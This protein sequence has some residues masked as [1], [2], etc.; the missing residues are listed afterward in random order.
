MA[1]TYNLKKIHDAPDWQ[2]CADTINGGVKVTCLLQDLRQGT[3]RSN[4]IYR[5]IP[6]VIDVYNPIT[7]G[8][9]TLSGFGVGGFSTAGAGGVFVASAGPNGTCFN[10]GA[11]TTNIPLTT[12]FPAA[13]GINQLANRG[14]GVQGFK[15]R[16]VDPISGKTEESYIVGNTAGTTPTLTISPA[17]SFTPGLSTKYY[18]L[19]GRIFIMGTTGTLFQ[20]YDIATGFLSAALTTTN[21]TAPG[22][23]NGMCVLDELYTPN[24]KLP[25]QGF[26]GN[27]VAATITNTTNA[28]VTGPT[29]GA[30]N[31]QPA[32]A[33]A[34]FQIRIV[35]D[36]TNPNSV[37]QRIKITSH[38]SANPTV[39]T[40]SGVFATAP[41]NTATYVIEGIGDIICMTGGATALSHT[42]AAGGWRADAT[43]ST[44]STLG[45]GSLQIPDRSSATILGI[46]N[47]IWAFGFNSL[48]VNKNNRYS[49]VY[50]STT[51]PVNTIDCLDIATL[52]WSTGIGATGLPFGT[53]GSHSLYTV[54]DP[55][56]NNGTYI[57]CCF[58]FS[59]VY[60]RYDLKN[61]IVEPWGGYSA[62]KKPFS[63]LDSGNIMGICPVIDG[64]VVSSYV[65]INEPSQVTA[66]KGFYRNLVVN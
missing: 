29:G 51:S 58:G 8:W 15:I 25:G 43:W 53:C 13:V 57:Y 37:G 2:P 22:A 6:S 40:C 59:P 12:A 10:I 50:F 38:T 66:S 31:T 26:F 64:A 28:V 54:Y 47:P 65:Y 46:S 56:N 23:D 48:D 17:L 21:L 41:S 14:D 9:L 49:G 19:S 32:N 20:Y 33:W 44:G 36:A 5:L 24:G 34:N 18:L 60:F 63:T 27:L 30:D 35:T 16:F 3:D 62:R 52:S 4:L 45:G 39:Y 61:R 11:T 55:W 7:D 1:T 42:Y